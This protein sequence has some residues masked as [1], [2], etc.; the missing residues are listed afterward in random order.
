M[1]A[2]CDMRKPKMKPNLFVIILSHMIFFVKE[3]MITV[4]DF[5]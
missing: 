2:E 3:L 4:S 1:L 5:R